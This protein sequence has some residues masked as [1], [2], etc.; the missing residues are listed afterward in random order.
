MK[1][2][3]Q[4]QK[5]IKKQ[6]LACW[7][8]P[9]Q[10]GK[11]PEKRRKRK[12]YKKKSFNK[13]RGEKYRRKYYNKLSPEKL[14]FLGKQIIILQNDKCWACG[15][16]GHYANECKN[17]KNNKLIETLGSLDYVELSE[18]EASDLTL[19]NNK[20]IVEIIMDNEYEESDYEEISLMME[21]SSVNLSDLQGEEF[22]IDN[23][24]KE[25]KGDWVLPII[26]KDMIYKKFI[27]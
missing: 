25:V 27:F 3:W 6:F 17:R 26:Q 18:D 23:D 2:T 8:S 14:R 10:L 9:H 24:H 4:K 20:G 16:V 13:Q 1:N 19:S 7:D 11:E 15:E 21:S 22:V 12:F 5:K